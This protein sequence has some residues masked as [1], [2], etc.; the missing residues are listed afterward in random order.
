MASEEGPI[1]TEAPSQP[2]ILHDPITIEALQADATRA[3]ASLKRARRESTPTSPSHALVSHLGSDLSPSKAARLIGVTSRHSPA[4]LTGAAAVEDERRRQEHEY[5][6]QVSGASENPAYRVQ[7]ELLAAGGGLSM[8][9]PHDAPEGAGAPPNQDVHLG[10]DATMTSDASVN[11]EV[12]VMNAD[13]PVVGDDQPLMGNDPPPMNN[14]PP[15]LSH[16]SPPMN[17]DPPPLGSDPQPLSNEPPP[18]SH[19][20]HPMG[21]DPQPMDNEPPH[22]DNE[23]A[24]MGDE[25]PP[26]G[27]EPSSMDHDPT[28]INDDSHPMNN[29]PEAMNTD[30]THMSHDPSHPM[31]VDAQ[32]MAHEAP[33]GH[34]PNANSDAQHM[35]QQHIEPAPLPGH[36]DA[37]SSHNVSPQSAA[38]LATLASGGAQVTGSPAP[39]EM[40]GQGDRAT[41]VPQPAAQMEDKGNPT[42]LSY[43]GLM[44]PSSS[45]GAPPARTMSMPMTANAPGGPKSPNSKKH[46]CPYCETEFTRHHNLKSHLLTHS[47]EKPYICQ[48]CQMRFRRLHDLK[49]HSKLHTGEK[50]HVCPK[51]DRK[52]ARG[53][54]LARHSKGPGG[55]VSRR[56]SIGGFD[57]S[58]D[59]TSHLDGDDTTMS[60]VVYETGNDAD[61]TEEDRR[62]L[63]L[64]G[65]KGPHV[66]GNQDAPEGYAPYSQ[67]YPSSGSATGRL[68]ASNVERN[69]PHAPNSNMAAGGAS[70]SMYAQSGMTESPKPLSPSALQPH[71]GNV[72]RQR[73]PSLTTQFQQQHFGR[74]QPDSQNAQG[75]WFSL[76]VP[77]IWLAQL[78]AAPGFAT[79]DARYVPAGQGTPHVADSATQG[80]SSGTS[81]QPP[82]VAGGSQTEPSTAPSQT[83]GSGDNTSANIFATDQGIWAY[84]HSLEQSLRDLSGRVHELEQSEKTQEEKVAHL[85]SEVVELRRQL[86]MKTDVPETIS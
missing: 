39:M 49:R 1:A 86:D 16:E 10:N 43:P 55:C 28:S 8:S 17:N 30:P 34:E 79:N 47:Q 61:M 76:P 70:N 12:P 82:S 73:S 36:E 67:T 29:E 20:S 85:T 75:L 58:E 48:T 54:A 57:A 38:T 4:P 56:G 22:M 18:L 63:G 77:E 66:Q 53:D 15:P 3:T 25:P 21:S 78:L 9:R 81:G 19:E 84:I 26:M 23:P 69:A 27:N 62:H 74:H 64:S 13:P 71:D 83:G 6:L 51:C 24:S 59:F 32:P 33:T 45:M 72:A 46:R 44:P 11:N 7:S 52:F 14:D 37:E 5:R 65:A 80:T 60:G 31:S 50:P 35:E 41:Y 2:A 40:D 68:F 42:S